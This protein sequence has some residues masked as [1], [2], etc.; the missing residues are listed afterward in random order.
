MCNYKQI[1]L[2]QY[3]PNSTRL[4]VKMFTFFPSVVLMYFIFVKAKWQKEKFQ[5]LLIM[6]QPFVLQRFSVSQ[7]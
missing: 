2:H 4:Q 1:N 5:H 6:D 3:L 7:Y